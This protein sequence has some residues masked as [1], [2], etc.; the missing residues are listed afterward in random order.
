[1]WRVHVFCFYTW[2]HRR[3]CSTEFLEMCFLRSILGIW[4]AAILFIFHFKIFLTDSWLRLILCYYEVVEVFHSPIVHC[5][6]LRDTWTAPKYTTSSHLYLGLVPVKAPD[7]SFN[8]FHYHHITFPP[9]SVLNH[10]LL[11]CLIVGNHHLHYTI[12]I[13]TPF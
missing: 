10:Q 3:L 8:L 9:P 13:N 5:H 2:F 11:H 6:C 4:Y 12:F 7:L 1:M